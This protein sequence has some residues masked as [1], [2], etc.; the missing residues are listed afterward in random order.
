MTDNETENGSDISRN[1]DRSLSISH[2]KPGSLKAGWTFKLIEIV[3]TAVIASALTVFTTL[4]IQRRSLPKLSAEYSWCRA[5]TLPIP[6]KKGEFVSV[7]VD[8]QSQTIV[9][10]TAYNISVTSK[11]GEGFE[12]SPVTHSY[13][14]K[15]AILNEGTST[16]NN[17]RL[18]IGYRFPVEMSITVA[19]N[20]HAVVAKIEPAKY[21]DS[22]FWPAR[23]EVQV[24]DLPPGER[25]FITLSWRLDASMKTEIG[26]PVGPNDTYIPELL[27]VNSKEVVGRIQGFASYKVMAGSQGDSVSDTAQPW[28]PIPIKL[29]KGSTMQMRKITDRDKIQLDV[30]FSKPAERNPSAPTDRQ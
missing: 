13:I 14:G 9:R 1:H 4:Y 29:N 20:V 16:A 27:Y 21:G 25:A 26:E 28:W 10:G 17:V 8:L 30:E 7:L 23:Y 12:Y 22:F 6:D 3:I 19:P 2:P 5:T 11:K 24:E 18:G 15:V